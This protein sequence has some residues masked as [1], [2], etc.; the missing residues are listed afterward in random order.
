MIVLHRRLMGVL[1]CLLSVAACVNPPSAAPGSA[2][3][4][5]AAAPPSLAGLE[6]AIT[7]GDYPLTTSVLVLRNG[8]IAHESYFGVGAR[9][10]LNDTRSAT[11]T[12]VALAVG[13]AIE[14]GLVAS[15]DAPVAPLFPEFANAAPF[16]RDI[17]FRDLLTMTSALHCDDNNDT[18]GNE[19]NMYPQSNWVDF[20]R[21]LPEEPGW[22]RAQ[23]GLGP[24]RYCT[25]GSF[26]LGQAIERA[27]GQPIDAYIEARVLGPLGVT[28]MQWDRSP[29]GEVQTGGG[30]ELSARDLG[31]LGWL[32]VERGRWGGSQIVPASW[33]DEMTTVRRPTFMGMRYGYQIWARD[34]PT[35]CG[36]V[37][38][39]FMAGNGG[40][41]VLA[42]PQRRLVVVVTREAYNTRGMHPQT[43]D[44]VERFILPAAA[45]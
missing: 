34:Y 2:A 30:L 23:D 9:D 1:L 35:P 31:K 6:A 40:N 25:A 8:E 21:S 32:I 43:M 12:I 24:W 5:T 27:S 7:R 15:V 19:E 41:H 36:E 38:A 14:D 16:M 39:W 17:T 13:A 28:N 26:L 3:L 18:P 42:I 4:Q 33:I 44:M 29:S 22:A 10:R 11:K 45:C 20:V 37:T